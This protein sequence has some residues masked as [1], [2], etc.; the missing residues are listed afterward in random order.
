LITRSSY[1]SYRPVFFDVSEWFLVW[2]TVPSCPTSFKWSFFPSGCVRS[3]FHFYMSYWYI[4][5]PLPARFTELVYNLRHGN[6]GFPK[7][8]VFPVP[9]G[10][11]STPLIAGSPFFDRFLTS[12]VFHPSCMG[13]ETRAHPPDAGFGS[14]INVPTGESLPFFGVGVPF[15][16]GLLSP[17][18]RPSLP[19]TG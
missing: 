6:F 14:R 15:Y 13:L 3:A 1:Q 4:F 16:P 5:C 18:V 8:K 11:S 10:T 12:L 7:G 19:P 17:F 2:I 9:T